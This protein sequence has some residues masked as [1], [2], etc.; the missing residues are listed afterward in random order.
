MEEF[1]REINPAYADDPELMDWFVWMQRAAA[2]PSAAAEFTR[3]QMD[4]DI[5]DVLPDGPRPDVDR[6]PLR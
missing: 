6:A 4:T 2:S 3:M 1:G 5:G